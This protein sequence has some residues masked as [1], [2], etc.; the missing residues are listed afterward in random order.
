MQGA[1]TAAILDIVTTA[2]RQDR[3]P[4]PC[5]PHMGPNVTIAARRRTAG[6]MLS[7]L[8]A[9]CT[10]GAIGSGIVG[11]QATKV[12]TIWMGADS[13][14]DIRITVTDVRGHIPVRNPPTSV[15]CG[16]TPVDEFGTASSVRCLAVHISAR[17]APCSLS[18]SAD[19]AGGIEHQDRQQAL[20][21]PD[22]L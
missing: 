12:C 11:I 9:P 2:K 16:R 6:V 4:L 19:R 15:L 13:T 3:L 7:V 8:L 5:M 22:F 1:S 14:G 20:W 18:P 17:S 10:A 21:S